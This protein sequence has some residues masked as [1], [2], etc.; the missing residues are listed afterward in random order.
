MRLDDYLEK[1]R[2]RE[3]AALSLGAAPIQAAAPALKKAVVTSMV[4]VVDR[5]QGGG[6]CQPAGR[7][8]R[9]DSVWEASPLVAV[10]IQIVIM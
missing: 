3:E 10:K 5:A 6:D 9:H 8:E 7:H 1:H 4:P 2:V